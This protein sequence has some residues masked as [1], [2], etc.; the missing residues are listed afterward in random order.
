MQALPHLVPPTLLQ[1]NADPRLCWRLLDTHRHIWV[2][3][4]WGHCSFLLGP[5]AHKILSVP[6]NCLF[7]QFCGSSVIKSHWLSKSHSLGVP[8][9]FARSPGWGICC[10][11]FFGIIVL[12][13]VGCLLNG[14]IEALKV[15][16]SKRLCHMPCLLGLLKPEPLSRGRPLL[17]PASAGDTQRQVWLS[18]FWGSLLLSLGPGM[19][20]LVCAL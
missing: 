12:Q 18:L 20:K 8:S 16:S 7:P 1:A 5:G 19:H 6:S 13:I 14:S 3:L 10:G 11:P 15:T 17:S 9:P 4:L 2:S